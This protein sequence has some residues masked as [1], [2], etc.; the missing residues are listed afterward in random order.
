MTIA[1]VF[2]G[3]IYSININVIW[4]PMVAMG[5]TNNIH[6]GFVCAGMDDEA[7]AK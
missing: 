1:G 5:D 3:K 2:C 4:P 7:T 6:D